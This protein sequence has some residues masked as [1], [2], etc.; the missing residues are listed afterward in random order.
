MPPKRFKNSLLWIFVDGLGLGSRDPAVNPLAA[1]RSRFLNFFDEAAQA[2]PR[3]GL[4]LKT[5]AILGVEGLPQSAT[6]QTSLF[7]GLN[8]Q[9]IIGR[10][11][12]GFPNREL[13]EL[14]VRWSLFQRLKDAGKKVT[15][16]NA[17]TPEF[18]ERSARRVSVTTSMCLNA[19]VALRTLEE[20][21]SDRALFMDFTNRLL[22]KRGYAASPRSP[23][24]AARVLHRTLEHHDLCLYEYFLTDL[25]GHRGTMPQ[26]VRLLEELERFVAAVVEQADLTRL[27][28]IL[29]SDH[30]NIED[31]TTARHTG[32]SVPTAIWGPL[33][34]QAA[35]LENWGIDQT[36]P[37]VG[38]FLCA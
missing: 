6:G 9:R 26:A 16:A 38:K 37:L 29:T 31:M 14:I 32:N 10:H 35:S 8:A 20:L 28:I 15:F 30:G 4:C 36:T 19:G 27:S 17:Y 1:F 33:R 18:F 12:Q 11:L 22:Q 34:E 13:R 21:E 7:T 25:V 5:D 3:G 24:E 2:L 23:E